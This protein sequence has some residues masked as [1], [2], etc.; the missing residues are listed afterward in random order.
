M[1]S[2]ESQ[3]IQRQMVRLG[4]TVVL[5]GILCAALLCM[6]RDAVP[7]HADP[8]SAS[9]DSNQRLDIIAGS[10]FTF[11]MAS[12]AAGLDPALETDG[13]SF[14]VTSQIYETLLNYQPGGTIPITGL[15]ESWSVSSNGLTWTFNLRSD[16]KFHDGTDLDADAVMYNLERWWDPA[17]PHHDGDFAYFEFVFGGYKGDPDCLISD[18]VT[19]TGQVQIILNDPYSP[20]PS[21]LAMPAFAI[22]SPTAMQA[23][24]L[25]M[26]PVGSGP[27]KFVEWATGDYI[28]LTGNTTYW[29]DGPLLETLVFQTI[30][31]DAVRLAALQSNAVQGAS[32]AWSYVPTATLDA[33]LKVV[34]RPALNTGY[35]GVNRSHSPLDN[36]LVR[37][38]IA[39][40]IDKQS[41]IDNHYNADAEGGQVATQL[42]P[43]AMWGYDDDLVDYAYDPAQAYSLLAQAGY[44]NGVTTTLWV[45]PVERMYLP[46]AMDIAG[47]IQAD[48][49]AV[50][51]TTTQVTY[52]WGTYLSKIHDGEADL[53]MLGWGG[54]NGHPD[55][56]FTPILCDRYQAFGSRDDALC[57]QLEAAREEPLFATQVVTYE[58]ASQRV[59]DTLPLVPIGH[60]QTSLVLRHNVIGFVPAAA[61]VESFR[62]VSFAGPW[63]IYLPL[64]LKNFGQ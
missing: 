22:A 42:L 40:A 57:N 1:E 53:F 45:L 33:N 49:Q 50:G 28:R 31:D 17:H 51:I 30:A 54:D 12:D 61:G 60:S 13:N 46:N 34:W 37:Q 44:T 32:L 39:H 16:V 56:F 25:H 2:N 7:A 58:W 27:F 6:L 63:T 55:N 21:T 18:L 19:D 4:V 24:T 23:G 59:H 11:A 48:L 14:M 5:A 35:L 8:A 62:E 41:I 43:P 29:G 20:L 36:S 52:D 15:A 3:L 26:F 47:S 9:R 38:A 64:T 10:A